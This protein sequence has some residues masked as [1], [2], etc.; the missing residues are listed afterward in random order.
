MYVDVVVPYL[1]NISN[2]RK[3]VIIHNNIIFKVLAE[4]LILLLQFNSHSL[5]VISKNKVYNI[6]DGFFF[7]LHMIITVIIL[8]MLFT[9]C[10]IKYKNRFLIMTPDKLY[11]NLLHTI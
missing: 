9:L 11:T 1:R 3:L 8:L 2:T 7:L 5:T 10:I 6:N 4:L